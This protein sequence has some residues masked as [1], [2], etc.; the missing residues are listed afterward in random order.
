MHRL[1]ILTFEHNFDR[2]HMLTLPLILATTLPIS[3]MFIQVV[4]VFL[5]LS[6]EL[7]KVL[8]KHQTTCIIFSCKI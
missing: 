2:I 7:R 3:N 8:E 4:T 5:T 1:R 6:T